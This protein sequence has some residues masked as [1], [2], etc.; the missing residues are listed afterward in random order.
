MSSSRQTLPNAETAYVEQQ[1]ITG[2]LLN[3]THPQGRS[4]ARFFRAFGFAPERWEEM[5]GALFFQAQTGGVVSRVSLPDSV[6]YAVEGEMSA[7][8]GRRPLVRT[9]WETRPDETRPRL[10]TAYPASARA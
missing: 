4:K 3:D 8:D 6:Q 2:Y 9:V 5:A 10:I 7:P 1:K